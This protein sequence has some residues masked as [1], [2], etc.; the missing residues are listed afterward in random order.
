[1]ICGPSTLPAKY[2]DALVIVASSSDMVEQHT[3]HSLGDSVKILECNVTALR[4]K[5][6]SFM[7]MDP[8]K[9]LSKLSAYGVQ[10]IETKVT[11]SKTMI[12][13]KHRWKNIEMQLRSINIKNMR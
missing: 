10:I 1:M 11:L 2:I 9:H 8:W 4:E 6:C 7:K 5:V 12:H 3:T 13:D